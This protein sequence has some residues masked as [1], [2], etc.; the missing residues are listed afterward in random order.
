MTSSIN[1]KLLA[2]PNRRATCEQTI[3]ESVREGF[4]EWARNTSAVEKLF[5]TLEQT[6][7]AIIESNGEVS[8]PKHRTKE[9]KHQERQE[10]QPIR[11]F[12]CGF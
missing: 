5:R 12:R 1:S 3:I 2:D 6:H 4:L 8:Q 10:K 9:E 11:T 7:K